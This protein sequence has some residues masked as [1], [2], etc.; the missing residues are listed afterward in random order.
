MWSEEA[1]REPPNFATWED[2]FTTSTPGW[3]SDNNIQ[4]IDGSPKVVTCSR[5]FPKY[6]STIQE[7]QNRDK[8]EFDN[9]FVFINGDGAEFA[10]IF[11]T[12]RHGKKGTKCLVGIQCKLLEK[13]TMTRRILNIELDK[14]AKAMKEHKDVFRDCSEMLTVV[15]VTA[16]YT[17]SGNNQEESNVRMTRKR[18]REI[19]EPKDDKKYI[20]LDRTL[21]QRFIP[22][23]LRDYTFRTISS[24][25]L[26]IN[27]APIDDVKEVFGLTESQATEFVGKRKSS[28]GFTKTADLPF[29]VKPDK[30]ALIEF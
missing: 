22:Q 30:S 1:K 23:P 10:N 7:P 2:F 12:C 24:G 26:N 11:F 18:A 9:G 25:R 3:C 4:F 14:N 29:N 28:G 17:D 6:G 15:L 19:D 21:L 16:P 13:T 5:K 8:Y 27:C 20:I